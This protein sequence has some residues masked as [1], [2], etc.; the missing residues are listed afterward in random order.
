[1]GKVRQA[2]PERHFSQIEAVRT[3]AIYAEHVAELSWCD[4]NGGIG[5][6]LLNLKQ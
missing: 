4:R 3:Q 2:A 5:P 1:M 6:S